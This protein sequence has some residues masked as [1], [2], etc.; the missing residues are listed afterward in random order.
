MSIDRPAL[1]RAT[2]LGTALQLAMVVTGHYVASVAM[3]FGPLGVAISILAGVLYARRAGAAS[4]AAGGALAGGL[5]ALLG[6]AVSFALG[7]VTALILA[8]G[9]LSS[10][11]GG[12][13]GGWATA[14]LGRGRAPAAHA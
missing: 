9:T 3:L 11:V 10:A 8:F 7:D 2:A 14:R 5:C 13:I 4:P 6:I 1:I 12:L